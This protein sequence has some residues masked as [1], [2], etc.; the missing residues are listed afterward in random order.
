V[1]GGR[2][3]GTA[4]AALFIGDTRGALADPRARIGFAPRE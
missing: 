4:S 2:A 3:G 1:I